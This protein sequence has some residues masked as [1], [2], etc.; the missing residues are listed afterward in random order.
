LLE[1]SGLLLV[2]AEDGDIVLVAAEPTGHQELARIKAFNGKVWNHP[3]I[4]GNRLYIR[5]DE[6]AVCYELPTE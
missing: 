2:A 3:V 4:I 1:D 5:N 6:E